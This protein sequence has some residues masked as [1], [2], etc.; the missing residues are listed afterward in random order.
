MNAFKSLLQFLSF[1]KKEETVLC[2]MLSEQEGAEIWI[3]GVKTP[4]VSPHLCRIP[5]N[6]D[7]N[8]EFK[9]IGHETHQAWIRSGSNLTYYYCQLT[10]I[11]L[12][13]VVDEDARAISL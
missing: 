8:V 3:D 5:K 1:G 6:R 12:R 2:M 11:P 13:L 7:V 9:L 10:R 4:Y